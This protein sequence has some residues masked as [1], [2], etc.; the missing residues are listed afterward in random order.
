MELF[1][2]GIPELGLVLLIALVIVG[3][4][5]FPE[6]ARQ[7]A[8]W[9]RTAR[10]FTDAVM[11][12]VRAAVD[13]IEQEVTAAND[14]VNPI[15]EL[16]ELRKELG[17]AAQDATSTVSEAA[18]LPPEPISDQWAAVTETRATD[19]VPDPAAEPAA[20]PEVAVTS[21]VGSAEVATAE[22]AAVPA[23]EPAPAATV[24]PP[25]PVESRRAD[26]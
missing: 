19:A 1:G 5:R 8:Q 12:D 20:D 18:T 9:I 6:V 17:T 21:T 26:A 25:N 23:S 10:S 3:P 7:I 24:T 11:Q 4:Q 22:V 2:V 16:Q 14:G 13:E 15:R